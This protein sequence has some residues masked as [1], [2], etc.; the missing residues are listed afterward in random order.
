METNPTTVRA[1][2]P[3]L[4]AMSE[5]TSRYLQTLSELTDGDLRAPSVLPGW[6]RG[7]VAAHLARN[8]DAMTGA[9]HRIVNGEAPFMYSTQEARDAEI[10]D[11]SG[12][13]AA[14][15]LEDGSAAC[16]R[17]LQAFN[18]MHPS[19]LDVEVPRLPGGPPHYVARA[20]A[21]TRL[22]EVII[23]HSD[24]DAGF[25]PSDWPLPFATSVVSHRHRDLAD[26]GSMVLRATDTADV[27]KFGAGAGPE[28]SGPV[29]ELAWW[30]VG[31]G[32]GSALTC[33]GDLPTIGRWR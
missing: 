4:D 22:R 20:F 10:E 5:A 13:P 1:S 28:V 17:L 15:M 31:R 2:L 9:V 26:G 3:D 32:D 19:H 33:E 25:G 8:A 18:E 16:G 29:A 27:W 11:T 7:H 12:R 14:E 23:H 30:L 21:S 6:T 24:L